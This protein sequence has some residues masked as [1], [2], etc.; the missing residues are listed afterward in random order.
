MGG[1]DVD[2]LCPILLRSIERTFLFIRQTQPLSKRFCKETSS[3]ISE[4]IIVRKSLAPK[5]DAKKAESANND[6]DE[7]P[8][9]PISADKAR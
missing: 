1:F 3:N 6:A 9:P 4:K 8:R 2:R 5:A 7:T